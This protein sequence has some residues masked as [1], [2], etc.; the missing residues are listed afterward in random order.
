MKIGITIGD[1]NGIGP[2]IIIKTLSE[3]TIMKL[4]TPV[5]YGSSKIMSYYKNMVPET[6]FQFSI[7]TH[8]E[9]AQKGRVNLINCWEENVNIT[10]GKASAESGKC[11]ALALD[12]AV[13]DAKAGVIQ[14]IVTAPIHKYA[15]KLS[16]FQ[17]PGHTE[18]LAARDEKKDNLMVLFSDHLVV[19]M[20]TSH[21]PLKDVPE[22][23]TKDLILKKLQVF[24]W[25]LIENFGKEK[26][27]LAVL[28]L[29]PHAGDEGT[30]G[31]E[32]ETIIRP[33]II[34]AKKSGMMV[35]GPFAADAFFG[36]KSW[37]K[38]D[39]ILAMY[40]DQGLIPFKTISFGEGTNF[41]AGLS[42]VRTSP[43]HGTAYDIAGQNV[44][45]PS[46][47]MNAIF[48]CIDLV[49]ARQEY[50]DDRAN[51]LAKVKKQAAG[52]DD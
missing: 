16:G 35:T 31:D 37:A 7:I 22:K 39:G 26:P 48:K 12:R 30:L 11:A 8:A 18:F 27:V 15:M 24:N 41:T 13:N 19:A 45:D 1:I 14:G 49:R 42:F 29:N 10:L 6:N 51:P 43:D 5:I 3:P 47:F 40:H 44:A 32:E 46:S 38:V 17:F 52:L 21:I 33:A 28:G 34:E 4:M 36:N 20:V 9:N 2:E 50:K 23:I 25:T